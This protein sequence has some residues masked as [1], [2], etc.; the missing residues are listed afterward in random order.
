MLLLLRSKFE[1]SSLIVLDNWFNNELVLNMTA[2][3]VL[4]WF[5]LYNLWDYWT[6]AFYPDQP[7]AGI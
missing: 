2:H 3:R 5:N 7:Y 1:N 6:F 4:N